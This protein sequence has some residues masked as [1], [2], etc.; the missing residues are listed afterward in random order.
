M[1]CKD[2]NN[3]KFPATK[4][5]SSRHL[6]NRILHFRVKGLGEDS[7]LGNGISLLQYPTNKKVLLKRITSIL[8]RFHYFGTFS[9]QGKKF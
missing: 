9:V 1:F 4:R 3:F 2:Y 7:K 6:E 5:K 8:N